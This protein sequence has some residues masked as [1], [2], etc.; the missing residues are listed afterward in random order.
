MNDMQFLQVMLALGL[1]TF[2]LRFSVV[3]F[4]SKLVITPRIREIF[5]FIP[6]AVLPA[7][8][9]PMVFYH[10]GQVEIL[11]GKERF[12]VLVFASLVCYLTKSM[13]LTI[14]SGLVGLLLITQ[15][16]I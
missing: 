15:F 3:A 7:L 10:K 8:I 4:S 5:T 6:V 14:I 13:L 12:F 11:L 16:A 9:A 1:G 2:L